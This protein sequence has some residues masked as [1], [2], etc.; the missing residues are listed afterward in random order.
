MAMP[1]KLFSLKEDGLPYELDP[2]TLATR[3]QWNAAVAAGSGRFL[4]VRVTHPTE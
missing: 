4:R 2:N 1:F 3:A